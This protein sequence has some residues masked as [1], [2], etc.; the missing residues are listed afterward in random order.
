[1]AR[2]AGLIHWGRNTPA[3]AGVTAS[4]MLAHMTRAHPGLMLC[5][6]GALGS[7]GQGGDIAE[8]P[9]LGLLVLDGR[10]LDRGRLDDGG[11]G[12][13]AA[14]LLRLCLRVGF[15]AA[16][17]AIDGDVAVAFLDTRTRR[18]WLGR[19][20]FGVKPLYYAA[21]REGIAF[22]SQPAP[23]AR[24]NGVGPAVNRRFTALVAGSHYRT[25]DNAIEESPFAQVRQL[26]AAHC[27]AATPDAAGV[28][29]PYWRL[30][31]KELGSSD[32]D[33]L[34]DQY[35]Q[36]LFAAVR[37][38]LDVAP[39]PAFTLSG[40]MD[41]SSVACTAAHLRGRPQAAFSSIYV[42]PTFD[43]RRE[44][45]DVI[46]AKLA[47][48]HPV[49][50]ADDID[51]LTT[52]ERLVRV[53]NE[54]VA[55]ATWLS[56]DIVCQAVAERG[57][58]ALFGGL[59]GDELNAGE[60]EYFPLF[61]ADL[62]ASG[63][64]DQLEREIS[65]WAHHHD[66]PIH[67]KNPAVAQ[68]LMAA[69]TRPG[70]AGIC[71][72]NLERQN[73]YLAAID[74]QWFDLSGF[75]PVM[76]HPFASFLA[77]RAYQDLTRETT[78]C[79]LRAEDRQSEAHGLVHFDPFLDRE[80]VEFMFN[81]PSR[82]KIRDGVTKHLLRK[83]MRA[84]L[85]EPTRTRVKKSGWNAPAHV[86]F[87]GGRGLAALSDIISSAAFRGRG[88]YNLAEVDRLLDEHRRIVSS[89]EPRENHMMF[90][91]QLVNLECWLAWVDSGLP[92]PH[93]PSLAIRPS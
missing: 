91:W 16:M 72:P 7:A 67:K 29:K 26:P 50:L 45:K 18:L 27:L 92:A 65:A 3:S 15:E 81:V 36:L 57:H 6:Q 64:D 83:A 41:S 52:I 40:G 24:L 14:L 12:G 28:A 34:A 74:P 88:L 76:E 58:G 70:S 38:R 55:T 19:D 75:V 60:Y 84:I 66:H 53:H 93:A 39:N 61:F 4:G 86:W 44:I 13:D 21:T 10:L 25:F 85:P 56:H 90:L 42:D 48:W 62:R 69:L 68:H 73:R 71:L 32:E 49:E 82:L 51:I 79:C 37:R 33:A 11:P 89:G 35:R 87:S 78:P 23:L 9:D 31:A 54:P 77:N 80:L 20:R 46:D 59:G 5:E 2:I 43:E 8:Q 47:E 30:S 22:A 63:R 1:M 17:Q